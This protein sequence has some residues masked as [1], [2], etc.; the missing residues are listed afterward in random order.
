M[1]SGLFSAKTVAHLSAA[2]ATASF[3]HAVAV[4]TETPALNTSTMALIPRRVCIIFSLFDDITN[5]S[6]LAFLLPAGAEAQTGL[7]GYRIER[8]QSAAAGLVSRR[9][10]L[11][12]TPVGTFD[13]TPA[14]ACCIYRLCCGV[15][16]P[17][18]TSAS[19]AC[20]ALSIA[21]RPAAIGFT[22]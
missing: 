1:V 13:S 10:P 2:P 4:C 19:P 5:I 6:L 11:G 21:R 3:E 7:A 8:D 12:R 14:A 16:V 17:F 15:C 22:R 18:P 9:E 20:R